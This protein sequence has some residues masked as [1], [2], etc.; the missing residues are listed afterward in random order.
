MNIK[1][2]NRTVSIQLKL[3]ALWAAFTAFYIYV[4][5]LTLYLPGKI[6]G[7]LEG[8]IHT[9]AISPIFLVVALLS[10]GIPAIMICLSVI[11]R[12]KINRWANIVVAGFNIP[13]ALFNLTGEAWAHMIIA[14]AIEVA[15][16]S[17][18]IW[19]AYKWPKDER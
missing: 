5:Y 13:Y 15:I 10:I 4:D 7:I 18:I 12:A 8:K 9:F 16:L 1:Q 19:Y 11:L 17:L 2:T 3:A 14:A 6:E